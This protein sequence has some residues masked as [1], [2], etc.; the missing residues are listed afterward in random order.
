[1]IA[2]GVTATGEKRMLGIVQTASENKRM[3]AAFLR[4]LGDCGFPLDHSRL[5]VRDGAKG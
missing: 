2:L 3:I 4:E 1:M 5:V